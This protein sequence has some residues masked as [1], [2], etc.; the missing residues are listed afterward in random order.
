MEVNPLVAPAP[1]VSAV[2]AKLSP[3]IQQLL[4][5]LEVKV[6]ARVE[7]T[8]GKATPISPEQQSALTVSKTQGLSLAE[9]AIW[10]PLLAQP[11]LQMVELKTAQGSFNTITDLTLKASQSISVLITHKGVQLIVEPAMLPKTGAPPATL[12]ASMLSNALAG[13][14]KATVL[15]Q[16]DGQPSLLASR[17]S[18]AVSGNPSSAQG[19]PAP[20]GPPPLPKQTAYLQAQRSRSGHALAAAVASALPK[21]EPTSVM[22]S[23]NTKLI[24]LLQHVPQQ[25]MPE[26]LKTLLPLL[27]RLE[28]QSLEVMSAK[29]L[30]LEVVARAIRNNGVFHERN[31]LLSIAR[32]AE[33][34]VQDQTDTDIKSLLIRTI[35]SMTQLGTTT[36]SSAARVNLTNDA[37][38]RLWLGLVR[39]THKPEPQSTVGSS[40][41][42]LLQLAQTMAENSLAKIQLNQYRSLQSGPESTTQG[43]TIHL[44]IPLKWPDGYGN[45][46]LQVFPPPEHKDKHP[47]KEQ[48]T[49][50]RLR[51]SIYMQLELGEEGNLAVE[52]SVADERVDATFWAEKESLRRKAAAQMQQLR[53]DLSGQGLQVNELRC[54]DGPP[55]EKKIKLDYALIDVKT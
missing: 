16:I 29:P 22:L 26:S 10:R 44:D 25:A 11:E 19:L 33:Q 28:A 8:V 9:R 2:Q 4:D 18:R 48:S 20:A 53:N 39:L 34:T 50:K 55:P 40:R 41:E 6:G 12:T 54:A 14:P 30:P 15:G 13:E 1:A 17:I 36:A 46:Y 32:P 51:W 5:Q 21:A 45:A 23:S 52:L 35:E 37:V 3:E 42:N 27:N 31:A 38:A 49:R 47:S 43:Q 7:A 24:S